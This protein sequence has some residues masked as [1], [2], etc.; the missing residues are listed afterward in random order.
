[1]NRVFNLLARFAPGSTT[2][3]PWLHRARGVKIGSQVFI[4]DDVYFENEYPECIEI[5]DGVHIS[6]R[7]MIIAH[8]RGPGKVVIEREA[9][10]GP[11]VIIACSAGRVLRIGAGAV[12]SAGCVITRN[13]AP[14][15]VMRPAASQVVGIAAISLST[16]ETMGE[17]YSGLT[18]LRSQKPRD[19]DTAR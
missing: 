5:Q 9:F 18:P 1:V 2:F 14:H 11:H 13:V 6:I 15:T 7:A 10:I 19:A 4:G 3:R 16:A 12:I 8:T 17:F